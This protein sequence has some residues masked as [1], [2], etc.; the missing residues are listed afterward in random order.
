MGIA[1]R[2]PIEGG[3]RPKRRSSVAGIGRIPW[4]RAIIT[5]DGRLGEGR[6]RGRGG[7]DRVTHQLR[8]RGTGAERV[9]ARHEFM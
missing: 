6:G 5:A 4:L 2:L 9:K 3:L 1:I 7:R 8:R